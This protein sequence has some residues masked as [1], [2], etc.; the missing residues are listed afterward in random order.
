MDID[1]GSEPHVFNPIL[2]NEDCLSQG[3]VCSIKHF[4]GKNNDSTV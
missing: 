2:L 3:S 1:T 4:C